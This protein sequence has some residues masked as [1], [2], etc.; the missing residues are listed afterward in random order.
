MSRIMVGI[1]IILVMVI[2]M[3]YRYVIEGY[4]LSDYTA[5]LW[6][7]LGID[8]TDDTIGSKN[9]VHDNNHSS[10]IT[11]APSLSTNYYNDGER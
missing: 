6:K 1:T 5:S 2:I 7:I 3:L 9:T 11:R 4:E 10:T 8:T